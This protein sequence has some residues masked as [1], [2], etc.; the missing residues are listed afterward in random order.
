MTESSKRKAESPLPRSAPR[1]FGDVDAPQ[2]PFVL[3]P[4]C[5][6]NGRRAPISAVAV[7]TALRECAAEEAAVAANAVARTDA[8]R[9]VADLGGE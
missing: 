6:R 1:L 3:A 4:R 9:D 5:R 8:P 2:E 7:A